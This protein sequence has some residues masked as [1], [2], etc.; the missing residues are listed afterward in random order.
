VADLHKGGAP[1]AG[2]T[3]WRQDEIAAAQPVVGNNNSFRSDQLI[4]TD[5]RTPQLSG[6]KVLLPP[7]V[8]G[9]IL[10][11]SVISSRSG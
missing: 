7:S 5:V 3:S 8:L 2:E 11:L 6:R 10:A 1:K 4:G 9:V